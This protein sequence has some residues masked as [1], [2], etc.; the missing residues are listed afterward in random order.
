MSPTPAD[1]TWRKSRRS[2][3]DHNC[4][5]V[6]LWRKSRRSGASSGNCIEVALLAHPDRE[7]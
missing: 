3:S 6:A 7:G 5:E 1:P 2:G 4:V